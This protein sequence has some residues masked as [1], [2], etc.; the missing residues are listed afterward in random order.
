M[1]ERLLYLHRP[2]RPTVWP[3]RKTSVWCRDLMRH[4][5]YRA[6]VALS[7]VLNMLLLSTLSHDPSLAMKG[8]FQA[9]DY[10]MFAVIMIETIIAL[11]GF[12]FKNF[13]RLPLHWLDLATIVASIAGYAGSE[14]S[15]VVSIY[16]R[17]LRVSRVFPLLLR[18]SRSFALIAG[19]MDETKWQAWI[20]MVLI[21]SSLAAFSPIASAMFGAT[22]NGNKLGSE[23][24]VS[25]VGWS[26]TMLTQIVMGGDWQILSRDFSVTGPFC[27]SNPEGGEGDCGSRWAPVLLLSVKLVV[28]GVL[29]QLLLGSLVAGLRFTHRRL[30]GLGPYQANRVGMEKH[31]RMMAEHWESVDPGGTGRMKVSLVGLLLWML[32]KPLG[33]GKRS[34]LQQ[35][36][37][38][39]KLRLV[40]VTT[41]LQL[42][43]GLEHKLYVVS[44]TQRVWDRIKQFLRELRRRLF[45]AICCCLPAPAQNQPGKRKSTIEA[46]ERTESE[47]AAI[48]D[49]FWVENAGKLAPTYHPRGKVDSVWLH[50][51][52][53][54][55]VT[56]EQVG[57]AV[58]AWMVPDALSPE[59]LRAREELTRLVTASVSAARIR[60][61]VHRCMTAE[62]RREAEAE[63]RQQAWHQVTLALLS[64]K[65]GTISSITA[66]G[67]GTWDGQ[68][69][70]RAIV[71]EKMEVD[72]EKEE[73]ERLLKSCEEELANPTPRTDM[74][75]L[76]I[77]LQSLQARKE[78]VEG[79]LDE[80]RRAEDARKAEEEAMR[81]GMV[82]RVKEICEEGHEELNKGEE[83]LEACE[84]T[85]PL[86]SDH[87]I[88]KCLRLV[89]ATNDRLEAGETLF[90]KAER[91]GEYYGIK[92]GVNEGLARAEELRDRLDVEEARM[93]EEDR[94]FRAPLSLFAG[95]TRLENAEAFA[96]ANQHPQQRGMTKYFAA[97]LLQ[98]YVRRKQDRINYALICR[99][100]ERVGGRF[101]PLGTTTTQRGSTSPTRSLNSSMHSLNSSRDGD[102]ALIERQ[103]GRARLEL[104]KASQIRT[105]KTTT[106]AW[107]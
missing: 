78:N 75:G 83:L 44:F 59:R 23:G 107:H 96:N 86:K 41:E 87:E 25:T 6:A 69:K 74:A 49:R 28:E 100:R 81:V 40:A 17:I 5:R 14:G 71:H 37:E 3:M 43:A 52:V 76:R 72:H 1:Y 36:T 33:F 93:L 2:R 9:Q 97:V 73:V 61:F 53:G 18:R 55:T 106:H 103:A 46:F 7:L 84:R 70:E 4:P 39:Q 13:V 98:A 85:G 56:F 8:L 91:A 79:R 104:L 58:L 32:P 31:V 62:Q 16:L 10:G 48:G 90:R 67:F 65:L 47:H 95:F 89:A 51:P 94:Q 38:E 92:E 30:G 101:V 64:V 24:N 99:R 50:A 82:A 27:T 12:G 66:M 20:C 102:M 22:R 45:G 34:K 15:A 80:Q 68:G 26:F 21:L 54:D 88:Q 42:V 29:L 19:G 60:A 11:V 63:R 105:L 35:L 57:S 77:T